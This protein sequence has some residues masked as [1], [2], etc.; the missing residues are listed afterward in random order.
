MKCDTTTL[1]IESLIGRIKDE[2]INLKPDFQRGEVWSLNKKKKLIDSILR[3]WKIPPIHLVQAEKAIDE[4]LDGQ[5]RL[6]AIRD[7]YDNAFSID[8][9]I[10]PYDSRINSLD[11]KKFNDLPIEVKR[12]FKK[13]S[14]TL[15][16]LTEFNPEEPAE[17]FYRLNQPV[18]LTAAE[19]RNAYV[20]MTRDQIKNMVQLF[21]NMGANKEILGFSN[22]RLAYDEIISKFCYSIEI[23]TLRKKIAANDISDKYRSNIPFGD[24]TIRIAE[25]VIKKFMNV[26]I[27]YFINSI[28][29]P[30]FSKATL[31]SW[32]VYIKTNIN[33]NDSEL[34]D[35]IKKFEISRDYLKGKIKD[36]L[37]ENY[38]EWY[39]PFLKKYTFFE[40]MLNTYNQ[41]ASMGSTDALSITYRDIIIN[42]F[43]CILFGKNNDLLSHFQKYFNEKQ[44]L[45]IALDIIYDEYEWGD[46]F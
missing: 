14:L 1:E 42:I 16:R 2:D 34:A 29:K 6:V 7:F 30:R 33:I 41:R 8:G 44:N 18:S 21:V 3:G 4:V 20:G 39:N 23:K 46:K 26:M 10:K 28:Y 12:M 32:F 13:Y 11:G 15:I 43:S 17:L 38:S 19:Q 45:A 31:F 9:S 24:E 35:T 40:V 22:S 25:T 27:K 37:F 5:Q 36:N